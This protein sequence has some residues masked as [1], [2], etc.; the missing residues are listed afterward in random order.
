[1][2][3]RRSTSAALLLWGATAA[4]AQSVDTTLL[5]FDGAMPSQRTIQ[6]DTDCDATQ[7]RHWRATVTPASA[8]TEWLS[9]DPTGH[10]SA[11]GI[12]DMGVSTDGRGLTPG[13][14]EADIAITSSRDCSGNSLT[15]PLVVG[16]IHIEL[17]IEFGV[18]PHEVVPTTHTF[19]MTEG[20]S[21]TTASIT[22]A[23]LCDTGVGRSWQATAGDAWLAITPSSG[24]G[25]I[26]SVDLTI[27]A[28]PLTAG[29]DPADSPFLT[30]VTVTSTDCD[31]FLPEDPSPAIVLVTLN[32]IAAADDTDGDAIADDVDN[33]PTVANEDQ[34]NID[35]DDL[36]DACDP[37]L[38]GDGRPNADDNC[39][40][41]SNG[42]QTDGDDDGAGDA[43]DE[44]PFDPE[45]T[46]AG[47]C[48]CEVEEID[49]DGDGS[50]DCVDGC[51]DDPGKDAPGEC[52]CGI[53]DIDLDDDG[54]LTCD[55]ECPSD[56]DK[57]EAGECGCGI[58]ETDF[59]D[60]G[61]PN[62]LDDCPTDPNK[63]AQ[64]QCGCGTSDQ[65]SDFDGVANCNDLCGGTPSGDGPD[66]FGCGATQR[67]S[68]D[69]DIADAF[70]QCPQTPIGQPAND[71]GC[72]VFEI[73]TDMD[74]V[75]DAVD[76]CVSTPLGTAIDERG[77]EVMLIPTDSD[78][79]GVTDVADLCPDTPPSAAV[80]AQGCLFADE[81]QG[82]PG[83]P[84]AS[85]CGGCGTAG[86]A[87]YVA[88][89]SSLSL[90]RLRRRR[91]A[92]ATR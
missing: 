26:T 16:T 51:P 55:D 9:V 4:H 40:A 20:Q 79:D 48:G 42:P 3:L 23:T 37:D 13:V 57:S 10:G 83:D 12:I 90:I 54:F 80:N 15:P 63:T 22:F 6:L 53:L 76:Q 11:T 67:D 73:D 71:F 14:Y 35:M 36:G 24:N 74:G 17:E 81:P 75:N 60:D 56:P 44:C 78:G 47:P 41:V 7:S 52:G 58:P 68:D 72:A 84:N 45:R 85:A 86:P 2:M 34:A 50:P 46:E 27:T 25:L 31:G 5:R 39:P 92:R 38:D 89:I 70:D 19:N 82:L 87:G 65:D 8:L 66:E 91:S 43:C 28:D 1:M 64:G 21:A 61:A 29:L 32:L 69:D 59:D 88:M 18:A 30:A 33:C 77:C 49:S 62:C